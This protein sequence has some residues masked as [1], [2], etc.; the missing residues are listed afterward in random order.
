MKTD[1]SAPGRNLRVA[2]ATLV[3]TLQIHGSVL[4]LV[5]AC[6]I[7]ILRNQLQV[8]LGGV[9]LGAVLGS[10]TLIPTILGVIGGAGLPVRPDEA[11]G[12]VTRLNSVEKALLYW[13]RLGSLDVGRR[14]RQSMFCTEPGAGDAIPHPLLCGLLEI[15]QI[16]A[17]ASVPI[18][19]V[20]GWWML[21]ARRRNRSA[22]YEGSIRAWYREYVIAMLSAA[23]IAALMSPVLIQGWHMLITL[24][25]ACLP[26]A[27]WIVARWPT[28]APSL[29]A[30]IALFLIWHIPASLLLLGH[31]MYAKPET[32]ELPRHIAPPE[33]RVLLP[34]AE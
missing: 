10:L 33:L 12:L 1:T 3:M 23:L 16:L 26:V 15:T 8:H 19:V 11:A 18:A 34:E 14:F 13:F 5:I 22:T 32:P 9:A 24:P 7:L 17:L 31:P 28:A 25:V 6:L 4:I 2:W 29:R 27:A 21:R 20:A 30:I